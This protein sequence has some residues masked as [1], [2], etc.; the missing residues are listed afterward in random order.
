MTTLQFLTHLRSIGVRLWAD[1]DKLA[2]SAPD[3]AL[4]PSLRAKLGE[5]KGEILTFLR[6]AGTS[7]RAAPPIVPVSRAGLM[8][9]SY[10][11]ERLWFISQLQPGSSAYNAPTTLRLKG[12]VKMLALEQALSE[13]RRRHESLRTTFAL[14]EGK[15]AQL[16]ADA[17]TSTLPVVN[18]EGL[19][20]RESLAERLAAE[21]AWRP[22]D[23]E[24][25]PLLR[26]T[27]LR[28][29]E[30]DHVLLLTMHHIISDG[31]SMT[32][33]FREM[34][35]LYEPFAGGSK[36][37]LPDLTIQ[38]PDFAV[39]QREWL[40]GEVLEA[41]LDYWRGQLG[42]R[43]FKLDLPTDRP[44]PEIQTQRGA[45]HPIDLP[46]RV[47]KQIVD[48]SHKAGVTPFMMLLAAFQVLLYHYTGNDSIPVG[49]SIA[50]RNRAETEGLIGFFVNTLVLC[51]DLSGDPTFFEAL[52]RVREVTI[53]GFAHQ[54]LPFEKLVE[55][56]QPER[57]LGRT[58]LVQV[59]FAL[60]N[61]PVQMLVLPNL[62]FVP[63]QVQNETAKFDLTLFFWEMPD[64]FSGFIE[65][66][67]DLFDASTIGRMA[68]RFRALLESI[69]ARPEMRLS[70]SCSF[71]REA[72]LALR[73]AREQANGI[74]D[75]TRVS[76]LMRN[77]SLIWMGQKLQPDAPLYNIAELFSVS[78]AIEPDHF[79]RAF[80]ALIDSSD[81]LR[82][83][84]AEVDGVP[85]QR[86]VDDLSYDLERLDFSRQSHPRA[87]AWA[88]AQARCAMPLDLETCAFDSALV[89]LSDREF[90]W[91]FNAHHIITDLESEWLMLR[92]MSEFYE[93]SIR[94]EINRERERTAFQD[95][96]AAE[97]EYTA[98]P[99]QIE[100][101][102][103]WKE[104]LS[105]QA[106]PITFYGKAAPKKSTRAQRVSCDLDL[107]RSKQLR[108][109]AAQEGVS[110]Q[111]GADAL[112]TLFAGLLL[113]YLFR[114]SGNESLS[115]GVAFH[116][117]RPEAHMHTVG[118]FTEVLPLHFT[119]DEGETF[120]SLIEKASAEATEALRHGQCA[121][122][123]KAH[124][125]AY[126]VLLNYNAVPQLTFNAAPVTSDLL[127][128]GVGNDDLAL[129]VFDRGETEEIELAFDFHEDI[130]DEERR[131]Q[132]ICHFLQV[133]DAFLQDTGRQ[134]KR[135]SL[136]SR[137]ESERLLVDFNRTEA[138]YPEDQTIPFLLE[139]HAHNIPERVAVV[140][141]RQA[142][143]YKKLNSRANQLAHHLIG[144]GVGTET[145]VGI[146]VDR[147]LDLIIGILGVM[148]AGGAYVPLDPAYPR[149][150][151]AFMLED[152]QVKVLVTQSHLVERLPQD[153]AGVVRL[154]RERELIARGS[155]KNPPTSPSPG[156]LAYVI[157][158]SG[159]TGRPKGVMVE[160][161]GLSN[162]MESQMRAFDL[163]PDSQ[164]LQ[165]ASLSFDA[166]I[167]EIAMWLRAGATIHLASQD[168]LIP[169]PDFIQLLR[170]QAITNVTLPPSALAVLPDVELP[171]LRTIIV[172]G[173][174]CPA[175][176]VERWAP[177]RRFFNAYGPTETTVWATVAECFA[178]GERPDIGCP[179]SNVKVYML[180]EHMQPVPTGV[181]GELFIGGTGL[182]RGYIDRPELT[183]SSFVPNPFGK[184]PG[185]RLYKTGDLAYYKS[186]GSIVFCGRADH[187]VK[188]RGFRIETGEIEAVL[189]QHPAVREAVVAARQDHSGDKRLVA[190]V[191]ADQAHPPAI[192]ELRSF[193]REK[194]VEFM[195]PAA[196]VMMGEMPLTRNGKMD[197]KRLP[198]PEEFNTEKL[199]DYVA[200]RTD[201]EQAIAAIWQE[202]LKVDKV[203][204]NDNF[205][206]LGG[207]SLLLLQVHSKVREAL[208]REL[209]IIDLFKYP[210]VS[211]L[212]GYLSPP[213]NTSS[214][215][216]QA[217][218]AEKL[219]R[220]KGRL[221]H[222]LQ[223]RRQADKATG[224]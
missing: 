221:Q 89:K 106:E 95:Y 13:L 42:G 10:S 209:S 181:T 184:E 74:A 206:D 162:L 123:G 122:G 169:G 17:E 146:S 34:A 93:L 63:M 58:P 15:P 127:H 201:I 112:L 139:Q 163:S 104:R 32:V 50:N 103:Y 99:Q 188:I 75:L 9:M 52:R 18:L 140:F 147:S 66:N 186:D 60:Q 173:E 219:E 195:I 189:G 110:A 150:R 193:L 8:P 90:V 126:D 130:F 215:Q 5:R 216:D 113:T 11:Q 14:V 155:E 154:D 49:T 2:Y 180:D 82:T 70:E 199:A 100:S 116:N 31:W 44:R 212:A 86:V 77:Q 20:E 161:R 156:D 29:D 200:P 23:L 33:L 222:Q 187:Q 164:I 148:K 203:G 115:L 190:Y 143:T 47:S 87:E 121:I 102:A 217:Q 3:R 54:D 64:G 202:A 192:S 185:A 38:Y 152:A 168:S 133:V 141:E 73:P 223:L 40:Q 4:T 41:H 165:F 167:F 27:L 151:L 160:H 176:V 111:E 72:E 1:G 132:T 149:E 157:Y 175:D 196:F 105:Q 207:H 46:T 62:S 71:D 119:L 28:L 79:Q 37:Q 108:M 117:R 85:Q 210:S 120:L 76:N 30:R 98:S 145:H 128:T 51:A 135:V 158:T 7:A 124:R 101:E 81:A 26:I 213:E 208:G 197:R 218:Q 55:A 114:V 178:G 118:L 134:V 144:L 24:R 131:N 88:W 109:I 191:V 211:S 159:S 179:I 170:E 16:I 36:D 166:S 19:P 92:R 129:H 214:I 65:Y 53:E 138:D 39:W 204:V 142:L 194:L 171:A 35:A 177:R 94:G 174:A 48:L 57:N 56:L 153:C 224:E 61:V 220:G 84:I 172:A 198:S 45:S 25:G 91:Y 107:N 78:C 182:A 43:L 21:E 69:V 125:K 96:V 205:F 67:T 83:V 80:D 136:L 12:A 183:A 6:R 59:G 22:F 68:E 137:E 97:R